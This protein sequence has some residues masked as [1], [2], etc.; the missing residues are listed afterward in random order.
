MVSET[1]CWYLVVRSRKHHQQHLQNA[2][3]GLEENPKGNN[4][5]FLS[6]A[7]S[8]TLQLDKEWYCVCGEKKP[9]GA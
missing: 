4:K 2:I 3:S 8:K 6:N 7:A 5:T 9:Q 1:F